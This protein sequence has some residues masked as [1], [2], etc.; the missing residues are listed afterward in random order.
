MSLVV[1]LEP[2]LRQCRASHRELPLR[3]E[4]HKYQLLAVAINAAKSGKLAAYITNS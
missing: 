2:A 3:A 1:E 4:D